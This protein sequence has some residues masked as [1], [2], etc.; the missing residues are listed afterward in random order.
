MALRK[1]WLNINGADRMVVCDPEKDSLA[2][3]LRRIGLTGVKKGCGTGICGVCSVLL[4]GKVVRSCTR[5]MRMIK[6]FSKIITIEGIGNPMNLHPIQQAFITCGAVQCGFCTPGFIVSSYQLLQENPDPTREEVRAWFKKNRNYCRCT[7]YKQIVDAVMAAA[8]VMRGEATMED[9]TFHGDGERY[10]NSKLP[11][12]SALAK[13]CGTLD[14]GEDMSLKMPDDTL[15]AALVQP[16]VTHHA[17]ILNIDISEAE[18]MPGVVKVITAKDVYALGGNNLLNQYVG[19]PRS[20]VTRPTR[21]IICEDKIYR[22]GDVIAVVVADTVEHAREAAKQV[23]M[24]YEQLPEYLTLLDA[25]LPDAQQIHE[26]FP[27]IYISQPVK[28]GEEAADVIEESEYFVEGSFKT[29]RQPHLNMEG[30]IVI[31]YRDEDGKMTLEC[32]SQG[33]YPN[34]MV[35]GKGIGLKQED[36]RIVQHG[37]IGA[38]FGW[39]IDS[40][41]FS[42]AAVACM[43]TGRPVS[44]VMSWEEHQH[45]VGKRSSSYTNCRLACDKDGKLTAVEYDIGVDH[46]A[47][48][49][50]GDSIISK[51]MHFGDPYV[52][53]NVR[54]L[55]RMTTTNHNHATAWRGY[56]IPQISTGMEGLMD[57]LAEK[58]GMDPFEF[59]YQ[60]IHREGQRSANGTEFEKP[61]YERLMDMARPYYYECKERAQKESTPEFKCGVGIAPMFFI[62]LGSV[63]DKAEARLELKEDGRFYVYN[64]YHDMG[65]GG[66]I[67]SL[68][69]TLEALKPL[70]LKPEDVQ[71]DI[72]DSQDC[73]NSGISAGSRSHFMNGGAIHEAGKLLLAAMKKPDGT[74]RTYEEMKAEGIPTSYT[75][76]FDITSENYSRMD[77]NTGKAERQPKPM[78]GFCVAEVG[79]E[80]KTG[81]PKVLSIRAWA[82]CGVIAN[83]LSAEGQAY[84]GFA[85]NI[86]Y[87]YTED[88]ND[89][90]KHANIIG[91]GLPSIDEVPDDMEV[92]WIE[93]NPCKKGPFGSNG[94]SE[95]FFGGEHN[96]FLNGIYDAT[97]VRIYELPAYPEKIKEGLE[98]IERGERTD[99][100]AKYFLGSDFYDELEELEANPVPADWMQQ[101][102]AAMA[103]DEAKEKKADK[104]ESEDAGI[105]EI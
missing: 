1:L 2:D 68:A 42:L 89:V 41:S 57:M 64:T 18:K 23:N 81:K 70:N 94:L 48:V 40:S 21:P 5:K 22:Y 77:Y 97:G 69:S 82:D 100:P 39:S 25:V 35:M 103:A 19:H 34:L 30:D 66:D 73:P 17:K 50:G 8:K 95:C 36:L 32:K 61:Q 55:V 12:P 78:T 87:A 85:Q 29:Q 38:S 59:R 62:P 47:Y 63:K 75:G 76:H 101:M 93:D 44:L 102:M 11:R 46:G 56:G 67:G 49:E 4:N 96:A 86:G 84:G 88:Y 31:A 15:H 54:G 43:A 83:Y 20:K 90:K 14:Y 16:R 51:Y 13:V 27:N 58:V 99:P 3:V 33:I 98:K 72:N 105:V 10:Y 28:K 9:I 79:V 65:Q 6:E 37:G 91:A 7:G 104:K 24:E 53:P 80:T 71:L 26:G 92:T 45:F 74:Y 52:V 60:N